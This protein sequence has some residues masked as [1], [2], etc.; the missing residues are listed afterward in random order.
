MILNCILPLFIQGQHLESITEVDLPG[1]IEHVSTDNSGNL[2]LATEDG[3][4]FKYT[5]AGDSLLAFSP[6]KKSSIDLLEAGTGLKI[7]VFYRDFQE[8]IFLDRFLISSPYYS[9]NPDYVG[10]ASLVTIGSDNDLWLLDQVDFSLKKYNVNTNVLEIA[11]P[12]DLLM[13][14][15]NYQAL[16]MKEYQNLVFISDI[17]SGLYVFDN[18]GNYKKKIPVTGFS[19]F[20]FINDHLY[21][22]RDGFLHMVNLYNGA[23]SGIPLPPQENAKF[24]L[25][26]E[27]NVFLI[28]GKKLKI[29]RIIP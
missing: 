28:S 14:P 25:M 27:K 29:L 1:I 23:T 21:Y 18:L 12:L 13:D 24:V 11:S 6:R 22:I 3:L 7:F 8:F 15:N 26:T 20:N 19:N 2:F 10:F 16:F 4:I 5:S 17:N 9:F